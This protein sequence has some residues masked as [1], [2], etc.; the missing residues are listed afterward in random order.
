MSAW[1]ETKQFLGALPL[2]DAA[3]QL[4]IQKYQLDREEMPLPSKSP[5]DAVHPLDG[6]VFRKLVN[7]AVARIMQE[8]K[9]AHD[10]KTFSRLKEIH[11][12][13]SDDDLKSAIKR[14]VKFDTDCTRNFAYKS[15]NYFDDCRRAVELSRVENPGF[16][17]E[18][19][20]RAER[21]LLFAMR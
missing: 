16:S 18:T 12:G 8:R 6:A 3:Y 10:G 17:D 9:T 11:P 7:E 5:G 4:W 20:K 2:L 19:Y 21:N 15:P 1:E 13:A 14:A